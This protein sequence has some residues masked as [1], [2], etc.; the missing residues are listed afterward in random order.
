MTRIKRYPLATSQKNQKKYPKII[1]QMKRPQEVN[2]EQVNE[3]I[4]KRARDSTSPPKDDQNKKIKEHTNQIPVLGSTGTGFQ[5]PP[6]GRSNFCGQQPER[7]PRTLSRGQGNQKDSWDHQPQ[8]TEHNRENDQRNRSYSNLF[9][10]KINSYKELYIKS[11]RTN[12]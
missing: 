11:S 12:K 6:M 2:Q 9:K 3:K 8:N 1:Q 4:Y 7:D 10:Y 5:D